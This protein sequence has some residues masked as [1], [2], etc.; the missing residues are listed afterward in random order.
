MNKHATERIMFGLFR[1]VALT[2]VAIV[3]GLLLFIFAR[4]ASVLSLA[5]RADSN[6]G[7]QEARP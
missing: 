6:P 7:L 3:L 4:G 5:S 1:A 2:L